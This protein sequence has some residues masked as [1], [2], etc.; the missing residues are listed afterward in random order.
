M[1]PSDDDQVDA[2][3]AVEFRRNDGG[4]A[5]LTRAKLPTEVTGR[6]LG[7]CQKH[8][9]FLGN[10]HEIL[11]LD[12]PRSHV[13]RPK[14]RDTLIDVILRRLYDNAD[15]DPVANILESLH[16]PLRRHLPNHSTPESFIGTFGF[17]PFVT[18]CEIT[19]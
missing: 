2:I 1:R 8:V 11:S 6:Q 18:A 15:R 16:F 19:A 10:E 13:S 7:L 9:C 3:A 14:C 4:C 17:S 5:G 12:S